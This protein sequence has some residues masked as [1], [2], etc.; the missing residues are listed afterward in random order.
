MTAPS[1]EEGE[2][3]TTA[4]PAELDAM[5]GRH[6]APGAR[7]RP[8]WAVRPW[9]PG[10][11]PLPCGAHWITPALL[12]LY[13]ADVVLGNP[14]RRTHGN[15]LLAQSASDSR[16]FDLI[17][18]D[19]S[20]AFLH[21]S[22]IGACHDEWLDRAS[23]DPTELEGFLQHRVDNLETLARKEHWLGVASVDTGG[24]HVFKIG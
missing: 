19:Q 11:V 14:D 2:R 24:Q 3:A 17:P 20:D 6:V 5:G 12:R 22:T 10:E 4:V 7:G 21:P 15:V 1:E 8:A 13:L 16:K 23:V 9:T 18:I